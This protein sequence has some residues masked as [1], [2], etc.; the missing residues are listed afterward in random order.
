MVWWLSG[1]CGFC[2]FKVAWTLGICVWGLEK[3]Y[4]VRENRTC[5]FGGVKVAWT[6]GLRGLGGLGLSIF[7]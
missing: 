6:L 5:G 4:L 7:Y 3:K 2:G 1:T